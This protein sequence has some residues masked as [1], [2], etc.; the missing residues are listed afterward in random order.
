MECGRKWTLTFTYCPVDAGW[1]VLEEKPPVPLKSVVTMRKGL[2]VITPDH[3]VRVVRETDPKGTFYFFDDE[4]EVQRIWWNAG[5]W[6]VAPREKVPDMANVC[7]VHAYPRA[8][9]L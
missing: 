5:R 9:N 2:K 8:A 3:G 7:V 1:L 4:G 6:R